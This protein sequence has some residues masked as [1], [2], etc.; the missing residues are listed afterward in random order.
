MVSLLSLFFMRCPSAGE[1]YLSA[2]LERAFID[3]YVFPLGACQLGLRTQDVL[4]RGEEH[5]PK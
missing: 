2:N 4:I 5:L 3:D 1:R